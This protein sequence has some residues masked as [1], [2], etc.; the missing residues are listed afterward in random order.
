MAWSRIFVMTI[1]LLC[2]TTAQSQRNTEA[3]ACFDVGGNADART[4]L[5][6]HFKKSE[7][8]LLVAESKAI[9]EI[10]AWDESESVRSHSSAS[11]EVSLKAFRSYRTKQCA[12]IASLAAGGTGTSHRRLLCEIELNKKQIDYLQEVKNS[13]Q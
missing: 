12:F 6:A 8:A 7:K 9:S 4:C 13:I 5:E 2:S 3:E 1:L 11:L 10:K